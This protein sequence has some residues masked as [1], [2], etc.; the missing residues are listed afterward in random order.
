M[1]FG[2]SHAIAVFDVSLINRAKSS[3]WL[4]ERTVATQS[5]A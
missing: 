5:E 4:A 2:P 3:F 1:H